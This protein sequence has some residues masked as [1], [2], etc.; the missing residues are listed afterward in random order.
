M[1]LIITSCFVKAAAY[2]S[3]PLLVNPCLKSPHA[4]SPWCNSTLPLEARI[5]DMLARMTQQEKI[6]NLASHDTAIPSLGLPD[7]EWRGEA[8]HGVSY[9]RF[10]PPFPAAQTPYSTSFAFPITLAMSFNRSMWRAVGAQIG[11]EVR[12]LMNA[13]N[14][15]STFW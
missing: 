4:S 10:K 8:E 11:T 7:Y 3:G 5:D 6:N 13:G 12:A 1:L 14:A 15:Y 2:P 9:A